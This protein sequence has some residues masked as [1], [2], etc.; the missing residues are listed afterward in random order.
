MQYFLN[1]SNHAPGIP[2]DV[3][4]FHYYADCKS[5]TT[6]TDYEAF[7]LQADTFLSNVGQSLVVHP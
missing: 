5:R 7:F 2:L 1:A 6:V 4:S 3:V